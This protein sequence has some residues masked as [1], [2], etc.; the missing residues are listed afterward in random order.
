MAIS[1][2][3]TLPPQPAGTRPIRGLWHHGSL[4]L[5]PTNGGAPWRA[6]TNGGAPW[7]ALQ[8][9]APRSCIGMAHKSKHMAM[10]LGVREGVK[11]LLAR[12]LLSG[13]DTGG[14]R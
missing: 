14:W 3:E 11:G 6:P 13:K 9:E 1:T 2:F 4:Y 10:A 5:A 12:P 8:A 7:L